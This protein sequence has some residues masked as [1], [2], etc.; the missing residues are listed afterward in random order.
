MLSAMFLWLCWKKDAIDG[1]MPFR[2]DVDVF[3]FFLWKDGFL[4]EE[5]PP[6]SS[7][8][9][10]LEIVNFLDILMYGV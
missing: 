7:D 4:L 2:L 6:P 8:S 9:E 1:L 3:D 5:L 10:S